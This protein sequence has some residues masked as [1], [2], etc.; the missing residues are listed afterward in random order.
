MHFVIPF[1]DI[2]VEAVKWFHIFF[3][4]GWV[5]VVTT[6]WTR[7]TLCA[8]GEPGLNRVSI[9]LLPNDLFKWAVYI[10]F[11]LF[12]SSCPVNIITMVAGAVGFFLCETL[13]LNWAGLDGIIFEA[14]KY[15]AF[16]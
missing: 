4:L 1:I 2:V 16:F 8:P 5:C 12:V 9:I 13:T 15:F 11:L 14:I 3:C 10:F 7:S 6:L